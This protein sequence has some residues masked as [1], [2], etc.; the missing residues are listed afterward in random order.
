MPHKRE[1]FEPVFG[2]YY[3][4]SLGE[5]VL[6]HGAYYSKYWDFGLQFERMVAEGLSDFLAKF[7]PERDLFLTVRAEERMCGSLTVQHDEDQT[8]MA[9]IRWVILSEQTQGL[10]LGK[11]M[12]QRGMD[13]IRKAGYRQ[14]RLST[15]RGL[16]SARSLY[17][18][19]GFSLIDEQPSDGWGVT[20][21]EQK[22]HWQSPSSC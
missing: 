20:V 3:P 17:E 15:F 9:R 11:Q 6:L 22:F 13:F 8:D 10:G 1:N 12:M 14:A 4:G 16:D 7:D 2:G 19:H 18:R 21:N 5:V